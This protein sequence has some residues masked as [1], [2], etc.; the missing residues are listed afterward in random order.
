[1][2]WSK[3]FFDFG[4]KFGEKKSFFKNFVLPYWSTR[5]AS[6]CLTE[7]LA[8]PRRL[9]NSA[10]GLVGYHLSRLNKSDNRPFPNRL[11]VLSASL[12]VTKRLIFSTSIRQNKFFEKTTKFFYPNFRP[13]SIFFS[14]KS[15]FFFR[16]IIFDQ[17][18][19]LE[20]SIITFQPSII[21]F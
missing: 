6:P 14:T 20:V 16:K 5:L 18:M 8:S 2:I 4:Q 7:V 13:K 12:I 1:M 21:T 11:T 9:S 17:K 3:I 10:Y 19:L 15:F